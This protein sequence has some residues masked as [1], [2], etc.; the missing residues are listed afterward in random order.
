V[1]LLVVAGSSSFSLGISSESLLSGFDGEEDE[2][3]GAGRGAGIGVFGSIWQR[4]RT[5]LGLLQRVQFLR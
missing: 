4:T 3:A 5:S 2:G 1:A